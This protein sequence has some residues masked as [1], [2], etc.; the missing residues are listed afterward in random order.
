MLEPDRKQ[1]GLIT[2]SIYNLDFLGSSSYFQATSHSL[3]LYFAI[4][5]L[6]RVGNM[7]SWLG[8]IVTASVLVFSPV[9]FF[10]AHTDRVSAD[11]LMAQVDYDPLKLSP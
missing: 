8:D 11:D 10:I 3:D 7:V 4:S 2:W 9:T 6:N 5:Q 1:K